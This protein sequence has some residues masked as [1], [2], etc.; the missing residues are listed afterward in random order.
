MIRFTRGPLMAT[1]YPAQIDTTQSLPTVV[2]NSTPVQGIVF[3]RLRDA[4]IAIESALGTQPGGIYANV[5]SRIGNLETIV[6]NLQIIQLD[7]DL[8]GTLAEPL[9][10]GLQGRPVSSTAP[11]DGYVLTWTGL[12][13]APALGGG[14]GGGDF[15]ANN[16]LD[17]TGTFQTVIGLYN[18][19]LS[20]TF[21]TDGAV[22]IW[23]GVVYEIRPLTADDILPGFNITAFYESGSVTAVECG[24][25]VTNPSFAASYS[26]PASSATIVNT[27]AIDSP[28]VLSPPYTSGTVIGSFSHS[29]VD[30]VVTFT[31]SAY[32]GALNRLDYAYIYW[33]PRSFGGLGS[34]GAVSA[35]ATGVPSAILNGGLGTL[36]DEG[37]Q[38]TDVGNAY[39][40][41]NPISQKI[42]L[43]LQHTASP[44][45]FK[46]QNG[47][48]FSMTGSSPTVF[49]FTNQYGAVIS[50]DL[51]E[52]LNNLSTTFTITVTS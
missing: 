12:A 14:G 36:S 21:P 40:P 47:F 1:T 50:M 18:H 5:S 15:V 37:I 25:T 8:G 2:D 9:V 33:E 48:A 43:L 39:G 3:N 13:W 31:L 28:L 45:T 26:S 24:F 17:G 38:Y 41:F 35:T 32:S 34:A 27:D 22:P 6:G 10:V 51:Y 42:Y 20:A 29:V 46:D 30:S 7:Q 52:S 23:D 19:P 4:V 16:D 49:N 11:H 44:H